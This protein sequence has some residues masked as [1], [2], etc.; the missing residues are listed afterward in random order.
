MADAPWTIVYEVRMILQLLG[1]MDY[2]LMHNYREYNKGAEFLANL[3][4]AERNM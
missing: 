4:F 3:G 2:N 1:S